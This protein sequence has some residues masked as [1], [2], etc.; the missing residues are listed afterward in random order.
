MRKSIWCLAAGLVL[1]FLLYGCA[2]GPAVKAT[3]EELKAAEE[4]K[5]TVAIVD[6][7]EKGSDVQGLRQI[8]VSRLENMLMGY[9]NLVD[10]ETV[11]GVIRDANLQKRQDLDKADQLGRQLGVDYVIFVNVVARV[12]GPHV[13][14]SESRHEGRFSGSIWEEVQASAE[15]TIRVIDTRTGNIAYA[16][17]K[18]GWDSEDINRQTFSDESLYKQT[19]NTKSI[20]H[21]I[22]NI[23]GLFM[24]MKEDHS[25][26]VSKAVNSSVGQFDHDLKRLFMHSGLVLEK[27]SDKEV[28]VNLGSAFGVKPGDTL[29]FWEEGVPIKDPRTGIMTVPKKG[30]KTLRVTG[31]TSGLT[32]VAK[33]SKK[34]VSML[35][36]G[37]K[38]YTQ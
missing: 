31:V 2:S 10:K 36:V 9:T 26:A 27:I 20:A 29:V 22:V 16:G 21:Q 18:K 11:E 1:P 3:H 33:G 8:V 19:L 34:T 23:A 4:Y 5:K 24:D 25:F 37:D 38:V 17:M 6:I 28:L 35:K 32:C 15:T 12:S 14:H 30:R 13:Q 7:T